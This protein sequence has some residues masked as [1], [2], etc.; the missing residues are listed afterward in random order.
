MVATNGVGANYP[1]FVAIN[2][3][4]TSIAY[5][6]GSDGNS[7]PLV[8]KT[9]NG[10][11]SWTS[12]MQ[13]TGNANVATG[14]SGDDSGN[15][16]WKKW[17]YG[18]CALGFAVS[19]VDPNRVIIT[20]LGFMHVTTNGGVTWQQA[21]DWVGCQN[22]VGSATPKTTFYTGNGAEDTSC[23]WLSWF[24]TNTLFCC[25]TDQRGM[26]ST[27]G[28]VAWMSP[29]SLTY[30]STYQT[31]KHPTNGLV[32]AAVSSVH[33][34]YAWDNYCEDAHIDGGSGAVLYSTNLG[35]TWAQLSTPGN[36]KPVVALAV[37]PLN[38]NR[39]LCGGCQSNQRRHLSHG[40]SPGRNV[41]PPRTN[42][43]CRPTL[44]VIP[45]TS[46]CSTTAHLWPPIR[47]ASPRTIFSRARESSSAPRTVPVGWIA[48]PPA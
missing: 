37:D 43:P 4:N 6:S 2:P 27:N 22:P 26:L 31:V 17:S 13:C 5:V 11:N 29:M 16:N 25:F 47:R 20:D 38:L 1:F 32:Y 24:S 21:Y 14:W 44:K 42:S 15:W 9:V 3:T 48:A 8:L 10:G 7:Q 18:E 30:N 40:Q 36:G 19:P 35:T 41:G 28:G 23:W 33:D 34:L 45:T 39:S 12:V 46:A